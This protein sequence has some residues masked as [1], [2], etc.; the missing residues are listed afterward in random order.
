MTTLELFILK[1][2]CKTEES[3]CSNRIVSLCESEFKK[4]VA[5]ATKLRKIKRSLENL[6]C[7]GLL[8]EEGYLTD[9]FGRSEMH[10][11]TAIKSK[12]QL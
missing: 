4:S 8:R 10:Y 5:R 12:T 9:S 3:F 2:L 7:D 6:L 11:R 1:S